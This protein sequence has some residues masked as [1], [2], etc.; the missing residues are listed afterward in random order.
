MLYEEETYAINGALFEVHKQLGP[1][2][3]EKAYQE[4]LAVELQLRNIPF[5]RE[6]HFKINYK[7]HILNQEF[8]A[9]FV[10]YDKII[11]ELKAVSTITDVHR[12]QVLNY[13][14]ITGYRLGLLQNLNKKNLGPAERI[15][16]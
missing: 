2:L 16:M 4:A 13:L 3:L 5:E 10:C 1:G 7:G 11:L 12:A 9:D 15:V 6:K 14:S 8:I